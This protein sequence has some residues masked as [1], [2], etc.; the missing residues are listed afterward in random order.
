MFSYIIIYDLYS[1]N[2]NVTQVAAVCSSEEDAVA[3]I[4]REIKGQA[5]SH[6]AYLEGTGIGTRLITNF[7]DTDWSCYRIEKH[8]TESY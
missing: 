5:W 2:H 7:S 4:K 6:L 1:K 8:V 3:W